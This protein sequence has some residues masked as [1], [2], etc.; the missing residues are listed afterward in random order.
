MWV[1]KGRINIEEFIKVV[2]GYIS[3]I[4]AEIRYPQVYTINYI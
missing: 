2:S 3:G 4:L 1:K